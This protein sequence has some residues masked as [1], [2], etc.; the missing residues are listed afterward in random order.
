MINLICDNYKSLNNI[1]LTNTSGSNNSISDISLNATK[2]NEKLSKKQQH[3]FI[4]SIIN[5]TKALAAMLG[6]FEKIKNLIFEL[7]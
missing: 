2:L 5:A 4:N 7:L 6:N 3:K 1:N